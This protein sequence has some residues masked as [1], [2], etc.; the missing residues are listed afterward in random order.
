MTEEEYLK[1]K[2]EECEYL[3]KGEPS[4]EGCLVT[5]LLILVLGVLLLVLSPFIFAMQNS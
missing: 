3:M 4:S 5:I 1:K 2:L